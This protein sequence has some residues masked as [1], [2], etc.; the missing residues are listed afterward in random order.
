MLITGP[1]P[2]TLLHATLST[3]PRFYVTEIDKHD[4]QTRPRQLRSNLV[5]PFIQKFSA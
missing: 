1:T 2:P 5:R 4:P 3:N